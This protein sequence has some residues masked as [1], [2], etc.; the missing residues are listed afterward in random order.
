MF[1]IF[2]KTGNDEGNSQ[3]KK[4][5]EGKTG[6]SRLRAFNSCER[7]WPLSFVYGTVKER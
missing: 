1:I 3:L 6:M 2:Q 7:M 5:R 4:E